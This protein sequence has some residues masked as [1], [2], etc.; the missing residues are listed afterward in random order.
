MKLKTLLIAGVIAGILGALNAH[1]ATLLYS[2]DFNAP[3]YSD[4]GINTVPNSTP[5]DTT[6]PGQG[7]WLNTSGAGTNIISVANSATNGTVA[8]TT[9]GQDIRHTFAAVSATGSSFFLQADITVTAAQATGDYFLHLGDGG[10]T[11]LYART[12]IKSSSTGFVMAL[13][14]SSGAAVNYGTT[15]LNF[16]TTYT[17]LVR[18]DGVAGTGNDTGALFIN[19]A[20]ADGSGDAAYVAATNIGIDPTGNIAGVYLRQ[21]TAG[22]AATLTIDNI[23]VSSVPEPASALLGVLGLLPL[24]R[25]RR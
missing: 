8:L 20:T 11:N 16:G 5:A 6:T 18:Y 24:L 4:G 22:S 10:T 17:I 12:Y 25:R 2:T 13:G 9:S 21:G 19:P 7:G 1:G 14:T 15:V 3:T 23:S